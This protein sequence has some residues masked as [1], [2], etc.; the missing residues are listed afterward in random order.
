MR[1]L[2]I[3][4]LS[5]HEHNSKKCRMTFGSCG[6]F[7][8]RQNS[9]KSTKKNQ[10]LPK[11]SKRYSI[12][13]FCPAKDILIHS[14]RRKS[15]IENENGQDMTPA[16]V[17]ECEKYLIKPYCNGKSQQVYRMRFSVLPIFMRLLSV[18]GPFAMRR[19]GFLCFGCRTLQNTRDLL[20]FNHKKIKIKEIE[21]C[22][23]NFFKK[24][25]NY[26]FE[27]SVQRYIALVECSHRQGSGW[28][29]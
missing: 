4:R 10:N 26:F 6:A 22:Y 17:P 13:A 27:C 15:S 20:D 25:Q 12:Q 29:L 1:N 24:K 11:N 19:K 3:N 21:M 23:I 2:K 14:E 9:I 16:P 18:K 5:R 7:F 28:S 8:V